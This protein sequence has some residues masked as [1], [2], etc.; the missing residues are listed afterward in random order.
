MFGRLFPKQFDNSYRGPWLAL[1][2][3]GLL[4]F[5]RLAQTGMG[6]INPAIVIRGPDGIL[7]DTF[8]PPAQAAFI[9]VFRLLCF[10]NIVVCLIGVLALVRYRAMVPLI[11]LIL[12][13]L[14]LAGQKFLSLLYPIPRAPDA[15]GGM[16]VLAM[17]AVTLFGGFLSLLDTR[18]KQ[19]H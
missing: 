12:I 4:L 10:F 11:Y 13:L 1:G 18:K 5:L 19:P 17:L 16:I 14:L 15:P 9:Y 8:N 2:I 7:L 3:L 6:L